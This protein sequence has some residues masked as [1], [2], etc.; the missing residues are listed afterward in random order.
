MYVSF[1]LGEEVVSIN[2]KRTDVMKVMVHFGRSM[3]IIFLYLSP[4]SCDRARK[5][6][7][8]TD[9]S[10]GL[11]L[12]LQSSDE[13]QRRVTIL[14]DKLTDEAK[15][16]LKS[17]YGGDLSE[18][19]SKIANEILVRCSPKDNV[20]AK[21]MAMRQKQIQ[22][23]TLSTSNSGHSNMVAPGE[24]QTV[25]YCKLSQVTVTSDDYLCLEDESFLNDTMIEFY[26]RYLQNNVMSGAD[27][28][29]THFFSTYFYSTLTKRPQKLK[30]RLHPVE[31]NQNLSAAEKRYERVKRWTKKVNIF[32]KDFVIVP[33]NEQ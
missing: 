6:L 2:I 15:T 27:K 3:P 8:M 28:D 19:D 10:M 16:L 32:E 22:S 24:M 11:W 4:S 20:K 17:M 26:L 23:G 33:I 25:T 1:L 9:K 18:L 7:G 5:V 21:A 30:N 14:P 12:E 29:R 13:T 31:D